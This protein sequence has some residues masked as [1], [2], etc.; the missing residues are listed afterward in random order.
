MNEFVILYVMT[1]AILIF[2]SIV[3]GLINAKLDILKAEI[4]EKE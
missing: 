4:E 1:T 3:L 2:D